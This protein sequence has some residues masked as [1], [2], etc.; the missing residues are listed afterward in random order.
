MVTTKA[1]N[2]LK[3]LKKFKRAIKIIFGRRELSYA[4]RLKKFYLPTLKYRCHRGDM[5]EMYKILHGI[6]NNDCTL[7][8]IILHKTVTRG[9][10]FKLIQMHMH[11]DLRKTFLC[12]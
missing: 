10:N 8:L 2:T 3:I 6:Y 5:I 4:D 12:Q 1:K 7:N 9:H 11:Y